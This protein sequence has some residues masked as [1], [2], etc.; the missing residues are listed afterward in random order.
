M[1]EINA[2]VNNIASDYP[3][4]SIRPALQKLSAASAA[5]PEGGL[6]PEIGPFHDCQRDGRYD[7]ADADDFDMEEH[8]GKFR[9]AAQSVGELRDDPEKMG[10]MEATFKCSIQ[11]I[12]EAL[13]ESWS[14]GGPTRRC[15]RHPNSTPY[16]R[17]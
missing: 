11:S 17:R 1:A 4:E 12:K 8:I 16:H 10:A 5:N 2:F 13:Q 15:G 7:G 6:D 14:Q 9:A 3:C